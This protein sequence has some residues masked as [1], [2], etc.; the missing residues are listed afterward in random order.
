M[1]FR[2]RFTPPTLTPLRTF[3][4]RAYDRGDLR[5]VRRTSALLALGQG[6]D[7][8]SVA[9][10]LSGSP[11]TVYAWLRAFWVE[12]FPSLGYRTS[13]GRP[14]KLTQTQKRHLRQILDAGPLAYG[15]TSGCWSSLLIQ[16]VILQ[17]FGVLYNRHYLC[18]LL[19][20]LGYS[21][22]KAKF[23]SAHLDPAARQAWL[24]QTWPG[25]L[26]QAQ[27]RQALL[28]FVDE[29]SFPQWG[30]LSYTWAL[31]GQQPQVPTSG[32]RKAYKVFGAVDVLSGRLFFQ[33]IEGRF[34]SQTYQAFLSRLLEQTTQPLILIQDGAR[35]HTSAATRAF[36]QAHLDRLVGYQLPSY[37]PDFNPIEHLWQ[38]VREDTTHNKYF[39]QFPDVV[40]AVE[41]ALQVLQ[42]DPQRVLKALGE[43]ATAEDIMPKAA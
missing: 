28:L 38:V 2:V 26:Q 41:L 23:V 9:A 37:S 33:G 13:P 36:F 20:N 6:Q 35:Y 31:Q 19:H 17:E 16:Q 21:Y 39:A 15:L 43:Y 27:Q 32:K 4:K 12:G 5:L 30:T 29:A 8:A 22:Q 40:H 25:I 34:T 10:D 7:M 11:K 14:P 3:W 18:S 1:D 42:R 24:E